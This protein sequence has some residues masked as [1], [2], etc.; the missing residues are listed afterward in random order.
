MLIARRRD[1]ACGRDRENL[2]VDMALVA[3]VCFGPHKYEFGISGIENIHYFAVD[4]L[5]KFALGFTGKERSQHLVFPTFVLRIFR[6]RKL[7]RTDERGY[8]CDF[9]SDLDRLILI[10]AKSIGEILF[11]RR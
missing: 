3:F 11:D 8:P 1:F 10:A 5:Y 4:L 2:V 7:H 9:M 6:S